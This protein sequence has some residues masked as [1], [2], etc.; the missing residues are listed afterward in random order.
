MPQKKIYRKP[1]ITMNRK[2]Y[3]KVKPLKEKKP[4][5]KFEKPS[6]GEL[7]SIY[8]RLKKSASWQQPDVL[9]EA[10]HWYRRLIRFLTESPKTYV[11]MVSPSMSRESMAREQLV[12]K[13]QKANNTDQKIAAVVAV[14]QSFEKTSLR[15]GIKV[16]AVSHFV[17]KAKAS[18]KKLDDRIA[19]VEKKYDP[20]LTMLSAAAG[21]DIEIGAV[22][23]LVDDPDRYGF[24][25]DSTLGKMMYSRPMLMGMKKRIRAEGLLPVFLEHLMYVARCAA[26]RETIKTD[27]VY[28]VN[29]RAW[30]R[31]IAEANRNLVKWLQTSQDAP[32]RLIKRTVPKKKRSRKLKDILGLTHPD[33]IALAEKIEAESDTAAVQDEIHGM[34]R[35]SEYGAAMDEEDSSIQESSM[36]FEEDEKAARGH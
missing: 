35:N 24:V 8:S 7:R 26:L 19:K 12:I 29:P 31:L 36:A 30:V 20:L 27:G 10:T 11:K 18:S 23:V 34:M 22:P 32:S 2:K 6:T 4:Q 14:I 17:K 1:H 5:P 9:A 21:L 28:T 25:Y 15:M 3:G 13:A 16:P 33:A